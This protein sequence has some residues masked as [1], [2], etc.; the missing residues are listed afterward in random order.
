MRF[1]ID[2]PGLQQ[3]GL[4]LRR[5][6]DSDLDTDIVSHAFLQY[7][8]VTQVALVGLGPEVFLRLNLDEL[9]GDPYAFAY[10]LHRA[11]NYGI[12]VQFARDF[13]QRFAQSLVAHDGGAGDHA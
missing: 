7:Q 3:A 6:L 1:R 9:S 11:L 10:P 13:G 12:H 5:Q 4:L 2:G 8:N